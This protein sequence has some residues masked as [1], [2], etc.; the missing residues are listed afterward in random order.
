MEFNKMYEE[1]LLAVGY[2]KLP[3]DLKNMLVA[4]LANNFGITFNE[5]TLE[6]IL[7]VHK[8]LKLAETRE[9]HQMELDSGFIHPETG[10]MYDISLNK[11]VDMTGIRVLLQT[12][13]QETVDWLTEDSGVVTHTEEEFID[14][15]ERVISYKKLLDTKLI[16][17]SEGIMMAK[18][19]EDVLS[20]NWYDYEYDTSKGGSTDNG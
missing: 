3:Y 5:V 8:T 19:T 13:N 2:E 7:D 12:T 9:L 10:S 16:R 17:M 14:L 15:F 11:Q 6:M 20:F 1:Q 18:T 4:D